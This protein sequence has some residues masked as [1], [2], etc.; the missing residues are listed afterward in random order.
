MTYLECI[1]SDLR[2]EVLHVR[3]MSLH[4]IDGK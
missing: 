1:Y 2:V 4:M 3:V